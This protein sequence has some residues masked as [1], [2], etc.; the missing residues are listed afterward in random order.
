MPLGALADH[1][2][3]NSLRPPVGPVQAVVLLCL[4]LGSI[5][6]VVI[7]CAHCFLTGLALLRRRATFSQLNVSCCCIPLPLP[8]PDRSVVDSL[9]GRQKGRVVF[10]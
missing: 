6:S 1:V 9:R 8:L 3:H 7:F 4:G 10:V 2:P 5:V